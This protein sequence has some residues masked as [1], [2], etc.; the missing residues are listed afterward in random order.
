MLMILLAMVGTISQLE[1]FW[2]ALT[3]QILTN[4]VGKILCGDAVTW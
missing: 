2:V 3:N 4:V 1:L